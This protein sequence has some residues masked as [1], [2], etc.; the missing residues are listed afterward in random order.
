MLRSMR[1]YGNISVWILTDRLSHSSD[2]SCVLSEKN[3]AGMTKSQSHTELVAKIR[4]MA[5]TSQYARARSIE[6]KLFRQFP[7]VHTVMQEAFLPNEIN[8]ACQGGSIFDA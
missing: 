2:A 8:L 5:E 6:A 3:G 7:E 1:L 4:Q